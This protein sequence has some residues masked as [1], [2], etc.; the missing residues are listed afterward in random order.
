[1]PHCPNDD[2]NSNEQR[3]LTALKN[4]EEW[5]FSAIYEQYWRKLL[6]ISYRLVRDKDLATSIVQ[7]L[8][9]YLWQKREILQ[10][11]SLESYLSTAIRF[12]TYKVLHQNKRRTAVHAELANEIS[13]D[14][15]EQQ[16]DALFLKEYLQTGISMLPTRCQL[17]FKLSRENYQSYKEIAEQLNIS[18]KS[19]EAHI[20]RALKFLRHMKTAYFPS[21]G[22][23]WRLKEENFFKNMNWL[24]ELK[25]GAS[26]GRTG[27]RNLGVNLSLPNDS[28]GVAKYYI[29]Y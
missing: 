27:T 23:A 12:S 4:G 29:T 5:A 19:V 24:N 7:D 11:D 8:F 25:L 21:V 20:S 26:A 3:L 10:I 28:V 2:L 6:G 18:E 15:D 13:S 17:V 22:I 14:I 16:I 9:I 1:M